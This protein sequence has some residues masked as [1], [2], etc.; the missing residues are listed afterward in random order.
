MLNIG[1][2]IPTKNRAETLQRTIEAT[3]NQMP[4]NVSLHVL[5]NGSDDDT[6]ERMAHFGH[7]AFHAYFDPPGTHC[8]DGFLR[9]LEEA[10]RS[11]DYVVLMSDEDEIVWPALE[12]LVEML[13]GELPGF[14]ST[15]FAFPPQFTRS[16]RSG[17][18]TSDAWF[19]SAF[20]C[21]GLVFNSV[22]LLRVVDAVRPRIHESA[23]VSI[24]A[25]SAL[26]LAMMPHNQQLWSRI[27]LCRKREQLDT[28][29]AMDDG[30]AYW[31]PNNRRKIL[32]DY[33]TDLDY[34][35]RVFPEHVTVWERA[36]RDGLL[37]SWR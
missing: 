22:D 12:Q 13:E 2:A 20:Y 30:S 6:A 10:A 33:L 24:Y 3:L 19:A 36:K 15:K 7:Q 17:V 16:D 14:V 25:E 5:D 37:N 4:E 31:Q 1:I 27:E 26:A 9:V 8:K 21:S 23:F 35:S 28:L 32:A 18:I 29:I 11:T 34:F